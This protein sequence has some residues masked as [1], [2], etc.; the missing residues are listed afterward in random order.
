MVE[1][2]GYVLLKFLRFELFVKVH[3]GNDGHM[4]QGVF[5][6]FD[7]SEMLLLNVTWKECANAWTYIYHL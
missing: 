5:R 7:S 3:S 2:C 4:P 6:L 1:I